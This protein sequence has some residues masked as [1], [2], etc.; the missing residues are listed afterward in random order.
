MVEKIIQAILS[1][2]LQDSD[3][4]KIVDAIVQ[5]RNE[6]TRAGNYKFKKG[7]RVQWPRGASGRSTGTF[8]QYITKGEFKGQVWVDTPAGG[9]WRLP[10]DIISPLEN[11]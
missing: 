1:G 10:A 8:D 5:A 4:K 2:K 7:D 11:K 9:S 3:Y 6:K